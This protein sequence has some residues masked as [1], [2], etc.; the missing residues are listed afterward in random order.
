MGGFNFNE[1]NFIN[2]NI[3]KFE[4]KLNTQVSRFTDK[5]AS[6]VTYYNIIQNESMVDLGFQNIE[7]LL[8]PESPLR[9][10]E[11]KDFPVYGIEPI[12]LRIDDGE[13]GLQPG[14]EGEL[15]ILPNTIKPTPNDFFILNY[16]GKDFVFMITSVEFDTIK[17]NN[18]YRCEFK[19]KYI[20]ADDVD[21]IK[22]QVSE[23]YT[24]INTN[25]GTQDKAI[26]EN[27]TVAAL[28]EIQFIYNDMA[29][30]Y[31]MYFFKDKYN[32]FIYINKAGFKIYDRYLSAFMQKHSLF[33]DRNDHLTIMVNNEDETEDFLYE[34]DN[35]IYHMMELKRP[36]LVKRYAFTVTNIENIYSVFNYYSEKDVVSV[37]FRH[38]EICYIHEPFTTAIHTGKYDNPPCPHQESA[39]PDCECVYNNERITI[40]DKFKFVHDQCP[41]VPLNEIDK[42]VINYMHD[43]YSSITEIDR[44]ALNELLFFKYNWENFIKIPL[45]L[46]S[47]RQLY[48][49]FVKTI[50][51]T[52]E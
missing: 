20:H 6:Y 49:R 19:V 34:Y 46:F 30:R 40:S 25:I 17:S 26:I 23:G 45:F 13:A 8:G 21:R 47:L 42:V 32:S 36:D 38:G 50:D 39:V 37:R 41:N 48:N 15:F 11:I 22:K 35:S 44:E 31:A 29:K 43:R 7:H 28:K 33:N 5:S 27:D 4:E 3:F 14:Y 2:N 9:F 24:C 1:Q 51:G 52:I 16:V 18:F 12:Q 10:S